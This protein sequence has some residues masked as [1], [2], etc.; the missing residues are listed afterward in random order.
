MTLLR[1]ALVTAGVAAAIG[2]IFIGGG[3]SW[4]P[5]PWDLPPDSARYLVYDYLL[6]KYRWVTMVVMVVYGITLAVTFKQE[7]VGLLKIEGGKDFWFRLLLPCLLLVLM[8]L[9]WST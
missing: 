7:F 2:L 3:S 1:T 8:A 9:F 6:V 4:V 5:K